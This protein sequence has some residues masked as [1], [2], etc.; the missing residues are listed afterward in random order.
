MGKEERLDHAAVRNFYDHVYYGDG[1]SMRSI[2]THLARLAKGFE[3]W[4]G[5]RVLDVGCGTGEWLKAVTKLGAV[6]AGIDISRVATEICR[7]S[8]PQ[9]EFHCGP[10]EELPFADQEFDFISCLGSLEHFINL[11]AVL[12]EMI[13]VAKPDAMF[14][15]LVPNAD[16]LPRRL[17]LYSGTQQAS[18]REEAKSLEQWQELFEAAGLCVTLRWKDLHVLSL[19]W[20]KRGPWYLWPVRAAQACALPLWPLSWQYQIYHLCRLN[21]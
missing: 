21:K 4:H 11:G 5:K 3:P 20:I 14:L 19:S 7:R 9:A 13:R 1:A 12:R 2:S 17:G 10:A 18:L 16:F 8:L 6:P 15:L